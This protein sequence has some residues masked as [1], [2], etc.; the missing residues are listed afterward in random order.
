MQTT[1]S[2][3]GRVTTGTYRTTSILVTTN[4][5]T[6]SIISVSEKINT[7]RETTLTDL[8]ATATEAGISTSVQG[9]ALL[10]QIHLLLSRVLLSLE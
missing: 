8:D 10:G 7:G 6:K 9:K 5:R 3:Q 2:A 1:T 4:H